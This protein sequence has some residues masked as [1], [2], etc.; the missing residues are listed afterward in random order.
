[1][2]NLQGRIV[3]IS[4]KTDSECSTEFIL[5]EFN[6]RTII[7]PGESKTFASLNYSSSSLKNETL[8]IIINY[9]GIKENNNKIQNY[10]E[11]FHIDKNKNI[12]IEEGTL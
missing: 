8:K 7:L 10:T 6:Q 11:I 12:A 4:T 9:V 1:M 3:N 5:N 2:E